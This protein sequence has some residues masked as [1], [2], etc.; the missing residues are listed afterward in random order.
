MKYKEIVNSRDSSG[1]V[2]I[3]LR[4]GAGVVRRWRVPRP[5]QV[6]LL[7]HHLQVAVLQL[8]AARAAVHIDRPAVE[9]ATLLVVACAWFVSFSINR[10][11]V[12]Q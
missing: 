11:V 9:L 10:Q 2:R 4:A 5:L 12:A 3:V 7:E 6:A 1:R 8:V